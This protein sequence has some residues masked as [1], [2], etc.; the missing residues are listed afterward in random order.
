MTGVESDGESDDHG[1]EQGV[2]IQEQG[3][4]RG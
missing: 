4:N 2:R 3:A 1:E